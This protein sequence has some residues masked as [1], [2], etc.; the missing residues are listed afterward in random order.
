MATARVFQL[1]GDPTI[2][3]GDFTF[4]H[5]Q[6]IHRWILQD[7]YAW[8]GRPRTTD[9]QAMGMAHCR[10]AFLAGELERVFAAIAARRPSHVDRDDAIATVAEHWGELTGVH[11]FVD[12]NSRSQRV[13][14][15]R[16][17]ADS[18]WQ[19]DWRV[20]DASAV[21]AAR[22]VAMATTDSS[23]LAA[24]L[25]PGVTRGG[26]TPPGSLT[27]TQ[28][29]R[30]PS[31]ASGLFAAMMAHRRAG[32]N[33][34]SFAAQL[35]AAGPSRPGAGVRRSVSSEVSSRP[36][37]PVSSRPDERGNSPRRGQ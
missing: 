19:V 17:F 22:H 31:R 20:I 14:F 37:P 11:P 33:A 24:Q 18:G 1:E 32:G 28:G 7:V 10:P 26:D 23:F 4:T 34:G 21:H 29:T 2:A 13:F 25:A 5:L 16:L 6:A 35:A 9:T 12:G 36:T 8:A 30:D 15:H 27:A 3:A